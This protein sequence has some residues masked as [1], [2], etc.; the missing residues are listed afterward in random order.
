MLEP[1]RSSDSLY[2]QIFLVQKID[3]TKSSSINFHKFQ[4]EYAIILVLIYL[5][6]HV[7]VCAACNLIFFLAMLLTC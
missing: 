1:L 7:L 5:Y 6:I 3:F 4:H 2:I